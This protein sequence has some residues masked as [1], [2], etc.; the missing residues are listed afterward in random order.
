MRRIC[1]QFDGEFIIKGNEDSSR[2]KKALGPVGATL[3]RQMKKKGRDKEDHFI[4][5]IRGW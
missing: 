2:Q 5:F 3:L 4:M 1:R